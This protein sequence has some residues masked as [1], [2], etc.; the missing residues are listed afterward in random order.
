[1]KYIITDI[2]FDF[3]EDTPLTSKEKNK[4]IKNTK[5]K[6][7]EVDEEENLADKVSDEMGWCILNLSYRE[8]L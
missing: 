8:S 3:D 1:M 6:T 4:I 7:F 2:R 5:S